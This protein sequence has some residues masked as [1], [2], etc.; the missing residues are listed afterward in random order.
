M[1]YRLVIFDLDGTLSD[2]FPWFLTVV[3]SFA[4]KHGFRRIEDHEIETLRGQSAREIITSLQVPYWKLP[5]IG[6]DMRRL[7]AQHMHEI[8]LFAGVPQMLRDLAAKGVTLAIVSSDNEANARAALGAHAALIHHY[9]C[10]ASLFGKAAK[11][12]RVLKAAGI[13]ARDALS[14]GDEVRDAGNRFRRGG[15]GLFAGRGVAPIPPGHGVRAGGG[16]LRIRR[17]TPAVGAGPADDRR[18]R[19]VKVSPFESMIGLVVSLAR[20]LRNRE[21]ASRPAPSAQD[22]NDRLGG[23]DRAGSDECPADRWPRCHKRS[24]GPAR[25]A[26]AAA[27]RARS[28][29]GPRMV[30]KEQRAIPRTAQN[31]RVARRH[32][33]P[34][35]PGDCA[36]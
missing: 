25:A 28:R 27:C 36:E 35:R 20:P 15:V 16:N 32:R 6:A 17:L 7:K 34:P 29:V 26:A 24:A 13:A 33:S 22:A 30:A 31:R 18:R 8:P 2:S 4:E 11:Y 23:G 9:D 5:V 14:I 10:G 1:R 3:N 12:K 19:A 21:F